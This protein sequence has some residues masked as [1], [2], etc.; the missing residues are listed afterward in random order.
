MNCNKHPEKEAVGSCVYC[1]KMFCAEC[2]VEV[3]GRMYCKDNIEKV[4]DDAKL[5][6][7]KQHQ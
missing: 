4:I 5:I 7:L 2:L 6:N 1:G 3:K